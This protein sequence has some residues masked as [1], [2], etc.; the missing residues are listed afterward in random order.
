MS[1]KQ[2]A[3]LD[4]ILQA[5]DQRGQAA[6]A[7]EEV[8]QREHAL[9]SAALAREEEAPD[10]LVCAALLHDLGHILSDSQMPEHL[11]DD[12]HDRHEEKAYRFLQE[13]FGDAVAEPVKLHVAAKRYLCTTEPSYEKQLSPTSLKSYHDQGGPM[14]AE[15]LLAFEQNPYYR[16][17]LRL[18]RWDD[19]AK[20][21]N[22][23]VPA[24]ETYLPLLQACL[25]H[26]SVTE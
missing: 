26:P 17:A 8:T 7:L 14:Q 5:F 22:K 10:S 2:T 18:R 23:D 12:L 24:L 11:E 6:Y 13:H 21:P 16:D 15:E 25:T 19:I 20:V 1:P 9:Q 3:A 4:K